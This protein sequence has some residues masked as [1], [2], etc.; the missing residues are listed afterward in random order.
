MH[1]S[2]AGGYSHGDGWQAVDLDY[3]GATMTVILPDPGRFAD[4]EKGLDAAFLAELRATW[5]YT[6]VHLSLPRWSSTTAR[7]LVEN[8][9]A[10][11]IHDLFDP[12]LADLRGIADAGLYVGQVIHQATIKV[13]EGGTEAAAAT[14]VIGGTTGGGPD[15]DATVKVDRPF[16]YLIRD[17][18][19]GEILFAGRVLDPTQR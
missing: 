16:I 2:I 8:L 3:T 11:G 14:A 6:E 7:D 5:A 18:S 15:G 17:G 12:S 4:V 1:G 13:D 9:R 19:T 10:L